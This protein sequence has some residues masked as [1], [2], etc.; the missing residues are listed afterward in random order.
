MM[1][2]SIGSSSPVLHRG[3][4]G[5]KVA[6]I[7][8]GSSAAGGSGALVLVGSSSGGHRWMG[9]RLDRGRVWLA[10]WGSRG[11]VWLVVEENE[12]K[13]GPAAVKGQIP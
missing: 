13:A 8:S 2:D 9:R 5:E 12:E 7:R 1:R 10:G 11:G 4:C 6:S 3:G